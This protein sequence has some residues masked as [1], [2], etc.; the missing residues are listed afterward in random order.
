MRPVSGLLLGLMA[1]GVS[2]QTINQV[3]NPELRGNRGAVVGN[4]TGSPPSAWRAFATGAASLDVMTIALPADALFPGSPPTHALRIETLDFGT[5]MVDDQGVDHSPNGFSLTLV[6][7]FRGAV[8]LRADNDDN[9]DQLVSVS[10]PIFD[11]QGLFTGQQPGSFLAS[12]GSDWSRFEGPMFADVAAPGAPSGSAEIAFR[13]LDEGGDDA[14]LIALPEVTGPVLS[15]RVPNP[16]FA[17]TGGGVGGQVNG[18]APDGWRAFAINGGE[19]TINSVP[20]GP[21]LCTR[22]ARRRSRSN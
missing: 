19:L 8:Y 21:G 9:S 4:V 10:I 17:G 18:T 22:A 6:D 2:A 5:P 11:N 12:A 20:L 7:G 1:V 13:L 14:V 16:G 3:P 15:E